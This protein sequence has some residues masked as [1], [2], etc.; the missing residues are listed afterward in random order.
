MASAAQWRN[1][2]DRINL[3]SQKLVLSLATLFLL[4]IL[5]TL[6]AQAQTYTI[7]HNFTGDGA[8]PMA[9]LTMDQAGNLYGTAETGGKR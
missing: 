8:G 1:S 9:G 5:A 6:A 3:R 4:T 2:F 7:L